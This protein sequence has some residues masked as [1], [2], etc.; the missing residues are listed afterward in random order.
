MP[1]TRAVGIDWSGDLANA[2]RKI[3]WCEVGA[4]GVARLENGRSAADVLAELRGRPEVIAG[5]DFAFSFPAWFVDAL[6]GTARAAWAAARDA[7]E[8]WLR[9]PR[10]PFW[11]R[12]GAG[13]PGEPLRLAERE[14]AERSSRRPSS[15]F[16][17]VGPGQVGPGSVRG[18]P[19]LLALQDGGAAVWPFDAVRAGE[20]LVVEIWPRLCYGEP[21]VKA[22][23][24]ARAAWVARHAPRLPPALRDAAVAA[25]D[26]VDALRPAVALWRA[27]DALAALPPARDAVEAKEGRI[28]VPPAA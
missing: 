8:A 15:V 24:D 17:L 14:A 7:G 3:W 23:A 28:W 4:R 22:R 5:L 13:V 25:D 19:G 27:R 18:M 1:H 6:G 9:D 20:P 21:V 16:T 2:P 12:A 26:A 10:A 11:R